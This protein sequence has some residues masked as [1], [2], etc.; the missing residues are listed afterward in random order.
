MKSH[1]FF[2]LFTFLTIANV[3]SQSFKIEVDEKTS[4]P[5]LIGICSRNIFLTSEFSSWFSKE[6]SEYTLNK[7]ILSS[8][9]DSFSNFKILAVMGTWCGDSRREIPRFYKILDELQFPDTNVTLIAVNRKKQGLN[10][11]TD[12]LNIQLVP[13]MI[14][15]KNG[16]E[17][18]RI[19]ETPI[20]SLEEDIYNILIK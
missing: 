16:I 7:D 14:F 19:I 9:P 2:L 8:I 17:I 5:M 18:G 13:T 4:N 15:Y 12:E 3:F 20:K 10:N 11:E 6:Y 1:T